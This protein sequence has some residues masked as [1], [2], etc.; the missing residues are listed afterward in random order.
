VQ[1]RD[2]APG[3]GEVLV[4][5]RGI[6]VNFIDV[7][8]RTGLY[9]AKAPIIP[10]MEAA[11]VVEAVG[12]GA[13]EFGV[14]DRVAYATEMGSYAELAAVPEGRLVPVPEGV[15]D[16][17]AAAALLQGMTAHYLTHATFQVRPGQVALVHAGAGG[18]GLLLTQVLRSLGARPIT[19]VSTPEKAAL[20]RAAG[21]EH[22][23]LYTEQDFE[24]EVLQLTAGEGVDVVYDSVGRTTFEKG[25]RVLKTRGFMVLYGQSSGPVAPLDL[26]PIAKGSLFVTRPR[27]FAYVPDTAAL[28][29]R[30]AAVY[31]WIAKGRLEVRIGGGYPLAEAARAHRDLEG[32]VT[33]GKLLLVP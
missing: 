25:F 30:A 29:D 15:T 3:P 13:R 4:R 27:L 20:S 14:G 31:D 16:D 7:Y 5:H 32:R 21:A 11:G 22:V 8:Y 10:G 33:T 26:G 12:E 9:P 1:L 18:V 24:A 28:R 2:P 6:G 17:A 23:I 19:T